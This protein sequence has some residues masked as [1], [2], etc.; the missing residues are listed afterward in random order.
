[1][2]EL[3]SDVVRAEL[4][5]HGIKPNPVPQPNIVDVATLPKA[6]VKEKADAAHL[7]KKI[8]QSEKKKRVVVELDGAQVEK[9]EREA[10]AKGMEMKDYFL[11]LIDTNI[12]KASIGKAVIST[13]SW[14][15]KVSGP[16]K[17][18]GNQQEH[19]GA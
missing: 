13:P 4:E 16:T 5:K 2:N 17:Y 9:L 19:Y 18:F 12:F 7:E 10:A 6:S 3:T 8:K 1:M 15:T 11:S 14:A